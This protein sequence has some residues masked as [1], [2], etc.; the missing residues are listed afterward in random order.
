MTPEKRQRVREAV[1][2]WAATLATATP[3]ER[4]ATLERIAARC[5]ED[6]AAMAAAL[7]RHA[8]D[9]LAV[10]YLARPAEVDAALLRGHN[11]M[12][13]DAVP[14]VRERAL[15]AAAGLPIGAL[16]ATEGNHGG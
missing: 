8:I 12:I 7:E 9:L 16:G 1:R 2:G 15:E 10:L 5:D 6:R 14:W 11:I 4:W 3:D 13:T